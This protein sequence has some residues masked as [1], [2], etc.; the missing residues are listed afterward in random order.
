MKI[1]ITTTA[2]TKRE[3]VQLL[4]DEFTQAKLNGDEKTE[5][6]LRGVLNKILLHKVI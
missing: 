2:Y 6:V 3:I 4:I 1:D 5:T